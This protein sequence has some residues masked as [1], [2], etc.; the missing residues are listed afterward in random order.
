MSPT[1]IS[2]TEADAVVGSNIVGFVM[3]ED[4]PQRQPSGNLEKDF[5]YY[6]Q[7]LGIHMVCPQPHSQIAGSE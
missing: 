4:I 1:D 3:T 5:F 2:Q 7:V 6:T